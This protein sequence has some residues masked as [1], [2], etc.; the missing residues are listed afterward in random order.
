MVR[1]RHSWP[2]EHVG[3]NGQHLADP[4]NTVHDCGAYPAFQLVAFVEDLAFQ[5]SG[6]PNPNVTAPPALFRGRT[7]PGL[8]EVSWSAGLR[9]LSRARRDQP[10]NA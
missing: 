9:Y 2:I 5:W 1:H 7:S 8:C 6:R 10:G 3:T 4:D